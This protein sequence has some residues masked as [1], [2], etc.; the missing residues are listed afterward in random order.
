MLDLACGNGR[1][2]RW[3]AAQGFHVTGVDRD[4]QVL[5]QCHGLG[6]LIEADLEGGDWPLA[7]RCFDA[8]VV[9]NYLWRPLLPAVVSAVDVDGVLIYET[10]A[11]GNGRFGRPSNPDFLLRTGEL[12]QAVSPLR[13]V[14]FEDG[15]VDVPPRQLQRIVAVREPPAATPGDGRYPLVA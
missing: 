15:F 11:A 9:T 12:L 3:L 2:L 7:G 6:E 8:V 5:A 13:V 4:P 14:A 10:F 1:H